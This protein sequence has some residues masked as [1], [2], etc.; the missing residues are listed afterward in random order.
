M[1]PQIPEDLSTLSATALRALAADI[2]SAILKLGTELSAD[3]AAEVVTYSGHRKKILE[4]ALAAEVVEVAQA[5]VAAEDA[6]AEQAKA[7]ELAAQEAA[8]A[9]AAAAAAAAEAADAEEKELALASAGKVKTSFG[10][11]APRTEAPAGK[12]IAVG[13]LKAKDGVEGV[14]SG[15]AFED[16]GQLAAALVK[17]AENLRADTAE[18]FTV[19]SIFGKYDKDRQLGDNLV[20]NAAKF[21]SEEL[22]A[23]FCAPATPYY[24]ISCMNTNRRPVFNSLPQFQNVSR[25]QVS[26]MPSPSLSDITAGY[27]IWSDTDDDNANKTKACTTITCGSP[28]TYKMY[29]V[30]RCLTVKN[31][32]AMSYP[33]LVEAWLNRLAAAHARLAE[34]T[35][36]NAM[37]SG[38]VN[39][40]APRLGYGGT[41][42]ILSTVLNYLALYQETQR[43]DL[44]GNMEAWAPRWVLW[45]IK[46]D[47]LRR[48]QTGSAV[49]SVASDSQIN[50]LFASC[51][52]NIH[53]FMDT[54]SYAVAISPVGASTLNLIP[55]SV[56]ILIAPPGKFA[57]MDRG[58]LSIGVTGDGIYRDT[59]SN[60][61]NQ[62]TFFFENFEGVVNTNTCPA[63]ILDIPVC[64]NGVQID[65]IVI[66]CQGQDEPGY[67]S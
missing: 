50:A 55:Q 47:L 39:I 58:E 40:A 11:D 8:A 19:A 20:M 45:G 16:W 17:R 24:G 25:M 59:T 60:A 5:E 23:A 67:Q 7:D 13:Y 62:F 64:W 44:T 3:V 52:I 31:L 15:D 10:S 28:T 43:W 54:P 27:G 32:L 65:D 9:E 51:G 57:L 14:R 42:T 63:H 46:M 34:Q 66:A 33:E 37:A 35:L 41:T 1:W 4:R 26:I 18:R 2:R 6:A 36:L 12:G 56:Q 29:G 49:P 21:D 22:T 30:W 53:W 61:R 48:R 38:A